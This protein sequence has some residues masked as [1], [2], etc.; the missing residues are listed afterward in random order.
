[1]NGIEKVYTLNLDIKSKLKFESIEFV[2][3][4]TLNK[5]VFNVTND[6]QPISLDNYTY[7]IVL[8]R[9]DGVGVQNN[10]TVVDGKLIYDVGTTEIQKEGTV[11]AQIE[12]YDGLE[13]ITTKSFS[14]TVIETM[15]NGD[16]IN[17]ET[18]YPVVSD[19]NYTH[20]QLI[21]SSQWEIN[22]NLNKKCSVTIVDSADNVV[23]GDIQ[24]IDMNNIIVTF[25]AAFSGKAY[26]N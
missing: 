13:R 9:P 16:L 21:P 11:T 10:P 19:S 18:E 1:M 26:L 6:G 14:F 24:Y 15:N 25:Q 22:H 17:S 12:I 3:G 7:K 23:I 4:D 20:T 2:Q 8:R 5:V